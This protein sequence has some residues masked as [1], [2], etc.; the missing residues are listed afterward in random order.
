M[1]VFKTNFARLAMGFLILA[2]TAPT[3]FAKDLAGRLGFGFVNEYSNGVP[4]LSV[5][6]GLAKDI[7]VGG[8]LGFTTTNPSDV[9]F[10]GKFY[11]NIFY[12]T[13][14]NFYS[15]A[16]LAY[17]KKG[18]NS[19][20]EILGVLGAEFFIP[21]VDSLGLSFEAGVSGSN[22]TNTFVLKTIGYTFINAGM[23]FY[24]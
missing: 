14:L 12:E 2:T 9:L 21:G 5:K 4:A 19:G 13:N 11:K 1:G 24:F 7:Q 23:H 17:L 16:A 3:L 15:A 6:Y 8:A 18:D 10:A 22:I 20:I